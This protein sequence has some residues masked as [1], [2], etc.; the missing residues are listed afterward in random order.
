MNSPEFKIPDGTYKASG[1]ITTTRDTRFIYG[2]YDEEAV[3][4][5]EVSLRGSDLAA[6]SDLISF[7]GGLFAIPNPEVFPDGL[8]L[9]TGSNAISVR[10]QHTNG[11]PSEI[12]SLDIILVG[13]GVLGVVPVSPTALR[14]ESFDGRVRVLVEGG[15]SGDI[16]GYNIYAASVPGGGSSG[17]SLINV[18][19]LETPEKNRKEVRVGIIDADVPISKDKDGNQ[20]VDPLLLRLRIDQ[21][22]MAGTSFHSDIDEA[23][24]I[25]DE[26][27]E[28]RVYASVDT[29]TYSNTYS[30]DHVRTAGS[31]STPPTVSVSEFTSIPG[32]DPLYYVATALYRDPFDGTE[33]ESSYSPEVSATPV[34]VVPVVAGVPAVSREQLLKST[35][36]A[37]YST[38]PTLALHPGTVIRDLFVDPFLTEAGRIRLVVDFLH[39]ASSFSTLLAIDDPTGIGKSVDVTASPYKQGVA[40]ALFMNP[41]SGVQQLINVQFDKLASNFGVVRSSG[42]SARGEVTFYLKSLPTVSISIPLGTRVMGASVVFRTV[43]A[44][45][46]PADNAASYYNPSKGEYSVTVGIRAATPGAGGNQGSGRIGRSDMSGVNVRNDE[47]TFG[48]KD[49]ESNQELAIRAHRRLASVDTGTYRGV[50]QSAAMVPGVDQIKVVASGD[51][52]MQRDMD[53]GGVHRGGKVDV[54]VRGAS[55]AQVTDTFSFT[56]EIARDIQFELTSTPDMFEF[57]ALDDDL[58]PSNPIIEVLN[59]ETPKFGIRNASTG[60]YFDLT[61]AKI[62]GYNTIRLSSKVDQPDLDFGDVVLGDYRY[63]TGTQYTLERQPVTSVAGIKGTVAG[64]LDA[65]VWTLVRPSSPLTYGRSS[66]AGAYIQ[67][68]EPLDV[69]ATL[70]VPSGDLITVTDESHVMIGEY[71]EYIANLGAIGLTLTVKSSDGEVEYRG[72]YDPSVD[73]DYTIIEGDQTSALG[74]QRIE[75]GRISDG[76]TVLISYQHDENFTVEYTTNLAVSVTQTDIDENKHLSADLLAK[77]AVPVAVDI[78]GTVVVN[79]GASASEADASI[80]TMLTNLFG[81]LGIGDP[82]RHSDVVQA[83][84][85]SSS[86]SYVILPLTKMALSDASQVVREIL[87][88]D[89]FSDQT[90]I[91]AWSTNQAQVYLLK[92]PL[93]HATTDGGGV[94]SGNY[95]GVWSDDAPVELSQGSPHLLGSTP[96]QAWIIGSAGFV[97]PGLS[98]DDTIRSEG[99]STDAEIQRQREEITANRVLVS[100]SVGESAS[101]RA[102]SVT[103]TSYGDQGALDLEIGPSSF[104]EGG[105]WIFTYDE[106]RSST[107]FFGSTAQGY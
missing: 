47:A 41:A 79:R 73:S 38:D 39:R 6:D 70:V 29:I 46:I 34:Y 100:L 5:L 18:Y 77:E 82:I 1:V 61:D 101:G 85:A 28:V 53:E 107:R 13:E 105:T 67:V 94:E 98:D 104:F 62:T 24:S 14:A 65:K 50:F 27:D 22:D 75:G 106:D 55:E 7:H 17:Y 90:P 10:A 59:K 78:T 76:D 96:G 40:E 88:S 92:A 103:Y 16:Y 23:L 49:S 3:A 95:T 20:I 81:G 26:A 52:L 48:G 99:Y 60:E 68:S 63:R 54:W 4:D 12:S 102:W 44:V 8:A 15:Y 25:P 91:D 74:I 86:V 58:T 31:T 72:P 84:D 36:L 89:Q 45:S 97:I 33:S 21:V 32:T 64:T 56:F 66:S 51:P 87:P 57:V 19:P 42:A 71:A 35:S 11:S 93:A 30:F 43:S 2:R 69:D 37:L 83:I 80:R 9:V